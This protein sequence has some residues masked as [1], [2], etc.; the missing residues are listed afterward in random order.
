MECNI[1]HFNH[2][3]N[4]HAVLDPRAYVTCIT[5]PQFSEY[6]FNNHHE[7]MQT[8]SAAIYNKFS[9]GEKCVTFKFKSST[10]LFKY[11][12]TGVPLT[13]HFLINHYL[14]LWSNQ[15]RVYE[16]LQ[17]WFVYKFTY[18]VKICK[19]IWQLKWMIWLKDIS[20]YW[21]QSG[22][23]FCI[24]T[25]LN[26]YDWGVKRHCNHDKAAKVGVMYSFRTTYAH[27]FAVNTHARSQLVPGCRWRREN[28]PIL[29]LLTDVGLIKELY[30]W[31]KVD[32][33]SMYNIIP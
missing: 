10:G 13:I 31:V 14:E 4:F 7:A 25:S 3:W 16:I 30:V 1:W 32:L 5:L 20:R 27:S 8:S 33:I 15:E 22:E 17:A 26:T 2:S 11:I 23:I 6:C 9:T 19:R 24:A 12:R 29:L 28:I 18:S 21:G